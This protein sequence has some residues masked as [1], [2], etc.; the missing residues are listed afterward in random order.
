MQVE[1]S[2]IYVSSISEEGVKITQSLWQKKSKAAFS[3]SSVIIHMAGVAPLMTDVEIP[4]LFCVYI[5]Q[6]SY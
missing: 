3:Q 6:D 2:E 5:E 4:G 1:I